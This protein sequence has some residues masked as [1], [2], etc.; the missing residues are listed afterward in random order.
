[1]D[2]EDETSWQN[3]A[4]KAEQRMGNQSVTEFFPELLSI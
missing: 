2:A 1:M 4:E 3:S